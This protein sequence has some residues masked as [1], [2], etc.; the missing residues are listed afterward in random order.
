MFSAEPGERRVGFV[1]WTSGGGSPTL[2]RVQHVMR[3]AWHFLIVFGLGHWSS[4]SYAQGE[5]P[6]ATSVAPIVPSPIPQE[7]AQPEPSV[8]T[9]PPAPKL[10]VDLPPEVESDEPAVF[11]QDGVFIK[12]QVLEVQ[13]V[14]EKRAILMEKDKPDYIPLFFDPTKNGVIYA[15]QEIEYDL[16][17]PLILRIGPLALTAAGVLMRMSRETGQF[18]E[19][20]FGMEVQK[21]YANMYMISFQWPVE[22]IPDG[23]I[24]LFSDAGKVLWRKAGSE[25]DIA[26]WRQF[27]ATNAALK[28]GTPKTAP[29]SGES[30]GGEQARVGAYRMKVTGHDQSSFGLFG[31]DIFDIP[32]WKIAEPF[33]F[34]VTKDAPEG[35]IALCSKRYRFIRKGGRYQV[36]AESKIVVP[37]VMV[38]DKEVTLKG[39]AVFI[40][41]KKPI[42]FAA[43]MGNGTYFEFVSFPKH[44]TVVDMVLNEETN[45]VE[46]IGFGP[47]PI[48]EIERVERYAPDY[49]DFLN[50][51]PTIGD[52]RQFWKATFPALGGALYLRGYGGAP[53]KQPFVFDRLPR[54]T[55]RPRIHNK[56]PKSTYNRTV[57]VHG[58]TTAPVQF[59][60]KQEQAKN[61]SP[62]AFEWS[63]LA[64]ERGTMNSSEILIKDG[65]HTYHAFHELYKGFPRELSGRASGV[66]TSN[67]EVVVLGEV[68]F[69]W[70]FERILG[71]NNRTFSHQRWGLNAKYFEAVTAVG[72][73]SSSQSVIKLEVATA[74]LKYRLTPGIWG[75]DHTLG[76]MLNAQH[77]VIEQFEAQ[78]GG[79][80]LFWARSMPRFFDNVFNILPFMRYPKWVDV[81]GIL[82]V[83]PLTPRNQLGLNAAVNFHGKILW[84]Q[85]FFGE[86]GFG[87]KMFQFDDIQRNKVVALGVAYGTIG[88]GLNF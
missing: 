15:H 26:N 9:T 78:M 25:E 44:V 75:R 72:G 47:P 88:L 70:W 1:Q 71:W 31:K 7:P 66:L 23:A 33:R 87:L 2:K 76:L 53:F 4:L 54:K 74:D 73:K 52:F 48:G 10:P 41:E 79:A 59:R 5:P 12:P 81:E 34:C 36:L 42:K 82:Y 69:Q 86:A 37:K 30:A 28:S 49:W 80:G 85:R 38:N 13:K 77:V 84:S 68:A 55:T 24:E 56:S 64:R 16:T 40:D 21:R 3:T 62:T 67:L 60:S 63:F 61:L 27:V 20:E 57:T 35:R 29:L 14:E 32:I 46:V 8:Q 43:L 6:P 45:Q 58:E 11:Q 83:L 18:L 51:A 17:N 65:A 50:F 22:L 19:F 39:S